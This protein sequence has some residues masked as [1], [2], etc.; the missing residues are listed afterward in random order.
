MNPYKFLNKYE[1]SPRLIPN[2]TPDSAIGIL[3]KTNNFVIE[4]GFITL[5]VI[6]S[7]LTAYIFEKKLKKFIE[8]HDEEDAFYSKIFTYYNF[9]FNLKF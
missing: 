3:L 9:F 7:V 1:V 2:Q 6:L 8:K 5:V 4:T